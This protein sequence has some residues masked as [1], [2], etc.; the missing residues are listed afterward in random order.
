MFL[1]QSEAVSFR[2]AL[3]FLNA[4]DCSNVDVFL[5]I[6]VSRAPWRH[7]EH[8]THVAW[9]P[10]CI[11][12]QQIINTDVLELHRLPSA[13]ISSHICVL[14]AFGIKRSLGTNQN[15]FPPKKD[16]LAAGY[17]FILLLFWEQLKPSVSFG[18]PLLQD[19]SLLNL[20]AAFSIILS[21]VS[22]SQA[23]P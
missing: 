12:K 18:C 2:C 5:P 22:L 1:R 16:N 19:Y 20:L 9:K 21:Q 13:T 17:L 4:L 10:P 15:D 23:V 8:V 14:F 11:Q 6:T 3:C 7:Q